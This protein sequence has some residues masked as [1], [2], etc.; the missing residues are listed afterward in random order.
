MKK[1]IAVDFD[2]VIHNYRYGWHDGTLYDGPVPKALE[3]IL[4]LIQNG[5]EIVIFT[6][7]TNHGTIKKWLK[8]NEFP[9]LKVTSTKPQ[10]LAYI[11]DRGIR[12]TNWEDIVK[13]F[14]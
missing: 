12:F 3:K 9:D 5:F 10:A 11:D 7:R 14:I 1:L 13:Y 4:L 2:G 8:K 6:T